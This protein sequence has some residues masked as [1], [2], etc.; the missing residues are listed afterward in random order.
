MQKSILIVD[1]ATISGTAA[2]GGMTERMKR[3]VQE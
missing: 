3:W 1:C 2:Y